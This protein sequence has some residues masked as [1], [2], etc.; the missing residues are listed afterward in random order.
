MD[1][2]NPRPPTDY[3]GYRQQTDRRL[4]LAVLFALVVVG[5]GLIALIWGMSAVVT[6]VPCLLGGAALLVVLWLI[7]AAIERWVG[8]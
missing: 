3:R 6:A 7:F 8:D 4:L 2:E 5:T 1:P